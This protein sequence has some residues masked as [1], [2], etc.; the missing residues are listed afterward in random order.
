[1]ALLSRVAEALFWL[2]RYV[3]RAES[4]ARLLDVT[5]HGRL[6]PTANEIAGATNTWSAL[7]ATLG[8]DDVL[9]E[10]LDPADETAVVEFLTVSRTNPSSIV[11]A[12]ATARDNARGARDFLSSESWIAVNRLHHAASQRSIHLILCDGL[13]EFCDEVRQGAQLFHGTVDSTSLHDEGWHWLKAGLYFE[14]SDMVARIVD[15]K[16]HVLLRSVDEIGGAVDRFQWA[17]LLRSLSGYEAYRRTNV[18]PLESD[19]IIEF[20]VLNAEFPR[21]LRASVDSLAGALDLAT[22][23]AE[24][25][26]RNRAL[27]LVAELRGRLAYET[28]DSLLAAGLHGFLEETE[29]T[30]ARAC[31]NVSEAFFWAATDAA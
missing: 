10:G 21:S 24:R 18:G 2:G 1:M 19:A 25:R 28:V 20:L 16:Y 29:E 26:L 11:S 6:E 23:G 27:R 15:A 14:R 17:A 5:Y 7:L 4:T 30:L 31:T 3:E 13:Y 22:A 12:L 9:P 8:L